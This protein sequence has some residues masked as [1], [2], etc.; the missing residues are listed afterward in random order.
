[1]MT[2][3]GLETVYETMAEQLDAIAPDKRELFMAKLVLLL[4]HDL[5]DAAR[6]RSLIREAAENLD[7]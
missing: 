2:P 3:A 4:S 6:V 1:M 5:A 7:A